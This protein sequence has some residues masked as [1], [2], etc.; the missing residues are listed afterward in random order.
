MRSKKGNRVKQGKVYIV[1]AGPGAA[2]LLTVRAAKILAQAE[3]VFYDALVSAEVLALCPPG[4]KKVPV[5][6]RCHQGGEGVVAHLPASS[7]QERIHTMLEKAVQ[8]YTT[9]VRLKGGDP[10]LFGRGGEEV[11]FLASRGIPWEVVPGISAG[12][13]GLSLLGLPVTHRKYASAVTLLTGSQSGSGG[14]DGLPWSHL[15]SPRQT[16]VFYMGLRHVPAIARE[17]IT[18]GM[19]PETYA[20]CV[21][22]LSCPDQK[23][24]AAPLNRIGAE[25]A[26]AGLEA[27]AL[28]V[29]GKV[30]EF[31]QGI[32]DSM[33]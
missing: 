10:C 12:V 18:H 15:V 3:I 29:V 22:R 2:D 21:S 19:Q 31:W 28:L 14:M 30:V 17:L 4:C 24:V 23:L 11:A 6:R 27:P 33:S 16:L 20:L 7:R 8:R 9:V 5:G 13:G 32:C 25:V 1:G 26:A